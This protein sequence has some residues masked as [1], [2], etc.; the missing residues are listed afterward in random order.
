MST[1]DPVVAA[2]QRHQLI[3]E[4]QLDLARRRAEL[5]RL[6]LHR[7]V[8][9]LGF[10]GEA[11][12]YRATAEA[13]GLEFV[14]LDDVAVER[15]VLD[16]VPANLALEHRFAPLALEEGQ[17]VAAFAEPPSLAELGR[18]RL[19]LGLRVRA[20]LCGPSTWRRRPSSA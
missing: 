17:L 3:D 4:R 2:L 6:P 7:A 12:T 20:R 8:V 11:P 9:D 14:S 5:Q 15:V 16:R 1:A 10:A 19:L 13:F 18:L